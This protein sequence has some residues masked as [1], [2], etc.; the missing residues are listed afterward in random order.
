MGGISVPDLKCILLDLKLIVHL[1]SSLGPRPKPNPNAHYTG[2]RPLIAWVQCFVFS[3][4]IALFPGPAQ[5][6]IA[7]SIRSCTRKA[8]DRDLQLCYCRTVTTSTHPSLTRVQSFRQYNVLS[9]HNEVE[10]NTV[11][12]V[13]NLLLNKTIYY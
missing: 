11:L 2:F 10:D 1:H 13:H 8:W 6:F 7:C 3:I 5:L 9:I 4:T 12:S